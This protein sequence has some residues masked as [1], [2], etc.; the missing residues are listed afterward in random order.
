MSFLFICSTPR[1]SVSCPGT[2]LS[3]STTSDSSQNESDSSPLVSKRSLRSMPS[4]IPRLAVSS[5]D[6]KPHASG[7]YSHM[8][9]SH[10]VR[11]SRNFRQ[12]GSR[13][14]CLTRCF[15]VCFFLCF[16]QRG[17][18]VFY[19][20]DPLSSPLDPHMHLYLAGCDIGVQISLSVCLST[21]TLF[22]LT[23]AKTL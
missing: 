19:G 3:T 9:L 22:T 13:S 2:S 4:I 7:E 16:L 11:G 20:R 23:M 6:D 1:S 18:N 12:A 10:L 14:I 8:V 21:I 15:V 5:D 17:I